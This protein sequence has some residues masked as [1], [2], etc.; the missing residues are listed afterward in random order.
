[1]KA[2]QAKAKANLHR[3]GVEPS[4][5]G[6]Y[7]EWVRLTAVTSHLCGLSR[8]KV[9]IK[10]GISNPSIRNWEKDLELVA[11]AGALAEQLVRERA[12]AKRK[13][14][15]EAAQAV[16]DARCARA[17]HNALILEGKEARLIAMVSMHESGMTLQEIGDHFGLT[18]ERI[19]QLLARAQGAGAQLGRPMTERAIAIWAPAVWADIRAGR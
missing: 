5:G 9:A 18:H 2:G 7:P 8:N 19:R 13:A 4:W 10:M 12:E 16:L 14:A 11:R 6:G 3:W 17:T 1:M 15:E